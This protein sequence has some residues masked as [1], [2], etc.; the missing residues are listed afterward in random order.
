MSLHSLLC[1][2]KRKRCYIHKFRRIVESF[3]SSFF[4]FVCCTRRKIVT[5]IFSENVS[6]NNF[7]IENA[8]RK[9]GHVLFLKIYF[10]IE[11]IMLIIWPFEWEH[12]KINSLNVAPPIRKWNNKIYKRDTTLM[13][14]HV[15]YSFTFPFRGCLL[16]MMFYMVLH[17][18]NVSSL[19]VEINQ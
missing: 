17:Y 7:F 16:K 5:D 18:L 8:E 11:I 6:E 15:K 19:L 10:A 3:F 4:F 14:A 9:S 1:F 12:S 2:M 13:C